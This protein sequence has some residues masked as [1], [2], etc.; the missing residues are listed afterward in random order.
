VRGADPAE[1][2]ALIPFQVKERVFRLVQLVLKGATKLLTF[3][4]PELFTGP[5]SSLLLCAHIAR[6]GVRNLLIVTDAMLVKLG[7]L[8]PITDELRR[9][10]VGFSIYD[11]VLPNP[12][13]DQIEA[14]L[15]LLKAQGCTA[16]LAV[17]GGS[18]IDTA[19]V[20]AAR[21]R[22]PLLKI[23]HMAGLLRVIRKPLP[24]YAV[25]TTAGTGAEVTIAAV[26]SDPSTTRKFA[27]M[28]PKLIPL[29]A[30]LDAN[31]MLGLPPAITAATGMDALTHAVEAYLSRNRTAMTD[32]E[33]I[34][35]TR[36][37]MANLP[38]VF[39]DGSDLEARQRMALAS[40]KAGVAFTTAGVGYV[41][42]IAHNFGAHYHLPH[43][44]ANAIVLP[45]VLEY[46]KPACIARLA[47]L[48]RA[49]GLTGDSDAALAEDFIEHV[50]A[51]NA[52]F[53][54]PT[55]VDKLREEDI[56]VI[57]TKAMREAHWTY[58][59]PR[60]MDRA[61]CEGLLREMLP[62]SVRVA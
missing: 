11:G 41:H 3:R 28:D 45:R 38:L 13:I 33:A 37:I 10:G 56:P 39:R 52:Q 43:G 40:F 29:G 32:H 54:I 7:L 34:E 53:G 30:A 12:T 60:Y 17:G 19:K 36:L 16:I 24:L 47:E 42:A 31:L 18:S 51:L 9:L 8:T 6:S 27:I 21:A 5:G 1:T 23:V 58:A 49:S 59:V 57:A 4:N 35:A 50:R 26:V 44:L 14:G 62:E 15:A 61:A 20:I 2:P 22:N 46:S 55:Q 48:A 25:P